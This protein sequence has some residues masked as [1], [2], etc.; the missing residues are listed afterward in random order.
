MIWF[1]S[2]FKATQH[3]IITPVNT[4]KQKRMPSL[5]LLHVS[6]IV[7]NNCVVVVCLLPRFMFSLWVFCQRIPLGIFSS[8]PVKELFVWVTVNHFSVSYFYNHGGFIHWLWPASYITSWWIL[9]ENGSVCPCVA[10]QILFFNG[11]WQG[12]V[13][14]A[15]QQSTLD[16]GCQVA[17]WTCFIPDLVLMFVC[18]TPVS[19]L[20]VRWHL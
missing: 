3:H 16:R 9:M 18:L 11:S 2:S 17:S 7:G 5:S 8:S 14:K 10:C 13:S 12:Q 19:N 1:W 4:L 6:S 20:H 15:A